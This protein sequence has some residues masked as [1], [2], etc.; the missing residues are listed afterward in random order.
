VTVSAKIVAIVDDDRAVLETTAGFLEAYGFETLCF[1]S[2]EAFLGSEHRIRTNYLLTDLH[3]PGMSG[4]ELLR[5]LGA[6][7]SAPPA[8][9]MTAL[10]D[11][12]VIER[13]L[14]L[15]ARA[16]FRKPVNGAEL[17]TE[18]ENAFGFSSL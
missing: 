3:M 9:V 13:A 11:R 4:L 12:E 7:T 14:A 16:V 15:G 1:E 6:Q 10:K 8:A 18:L 2:A 5:N 17:M